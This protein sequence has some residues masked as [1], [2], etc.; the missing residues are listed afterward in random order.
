MHRVALLLLIGAVALTVAKTP[1]EHC[2]SAGDRGIV[3]KQWRGLFENQ[4]AKFRAGVARLL[5][6][7]VVTDYPAAKDLFKNVDIDNPKGG[8]FTAHSMRIFNAL[9]MA[10]NLLDN[11]ESLDEALDHL[12]DQHQARAGVKREY[13]TA[14]G[15]A[16][17]R[18]LPKILDHYDIMAWKQCAGY[19]LKKVSSKL[20]E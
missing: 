5:L 14:F 11:P 4:D 1:I 12:A 2:C 18:G 10:I 3:Q 17:N 6:Q 7:R 8:A 20:Q 9:D 16:M 15:Q 13:F 19:I